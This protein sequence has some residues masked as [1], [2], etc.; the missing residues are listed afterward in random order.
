LKEAAAMPTKQDR[1][2]VI[3]VRKGASRRE[4]YAKVRS[5][6]TA[7][8]LAKCIQQEETFPIEPLLAELNAIN[9][10]EARKRRGKKKD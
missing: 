2:R 10:E 5:S 8:D 7:D 9:R 3:R 4:I 1:I 6:F